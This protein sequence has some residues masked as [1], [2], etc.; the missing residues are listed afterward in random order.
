MRTVLLLLAAL[1]LLAQVPLAPTPPTAP[2]PAKTSAPPK[3]SAPANTT[4]LWSYETP[5][6]F[7]LPEPSYRFPTPI[8]Q[9]LLQ[10]VQPSPALCREYHAVFLDKHRFATW[11]RKV[12]TEQ[13]SQRAQAAR[14]EATV[15][16]SDPSRTST[17][18][19]TVLSTAKARPGRAQ[20]AGASER[21]LDAL[22]LWDP[23]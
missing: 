12:L 13:Q 23:E 21:C 5:R 8:K 14:T 10:V 3:A 20:D 6:G 2:T 15:L 1:P 4:V 9:A 16:S 18:G 17:S 7:Q 11:L 19:G 22:K